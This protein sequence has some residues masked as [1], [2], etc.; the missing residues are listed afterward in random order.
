MSL[1]AS[2][3][4]A[5]LERRFGG[6]RRLYGVS[7]YERVRQLLDAKLIADVADLYELDADRLAELERFAEQSA[8]Q[9]VRSI[10]DSKSRFVTT[11]SANSTASLDA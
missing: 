6:L 3:T 9:L 8:A 1:A 2:L 10:A 5:D 11:R 7:A 4:E